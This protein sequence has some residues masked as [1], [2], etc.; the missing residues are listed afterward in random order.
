MRKTFL[1]GVAALAL[2]AGCA[3]G[4]GAGPTLSQAQ[5]EASAIL[6]ALQSG[7]AI[8]TGA[9]TTTPAQAAAV[10]NVMNIAKTAVVAF[11]GVPSSGSAGQV[12]EQVSTALEAVLAVLP[13]DPAT[14]TA[15][16][17]GM[18]VIDGLVAT[19]AATPA[20]AVGEAAPGAAV[21]PP[22]PIPAPHRLPPTG[23][24]PRG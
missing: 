17:A 9:A 5:S 12:A 2:L 13:I 6:A 14:K 15:I 4:T 10:E 3:N 8:Y 7:A 11:G 22:V 20:L 1:A 24:P 19:F 16:D 23:S 21:A 18:A